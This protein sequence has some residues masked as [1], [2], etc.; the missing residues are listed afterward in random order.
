MIV[1]CNK[2]NIDCVGCE[3]GTSH[4]RINV[5]DS[6]VNNYPCTKWSKCFNSYKGTMSVRCVREHEMRRYERGIR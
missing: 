2:L 5:F 4:E 6:T 1:I 3:H